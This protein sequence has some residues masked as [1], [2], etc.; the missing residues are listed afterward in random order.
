L[1]SETS[2]ANLPPAIWGHRPRNASWKQLSR[3]RH[4]GT[5]SAEPGIAGGVRPPLPVPVGEGVQC[6]ILHA[7]PARRWAPSGMT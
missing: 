1:A 4:P 3:G 5:A 6:P 2:L 7:I